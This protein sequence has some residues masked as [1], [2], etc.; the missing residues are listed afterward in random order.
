[1]KDGPSDGGGE[2]LVSLT[3]GFMGTMADGQLA[4]RW[5]TPECSW[6]AAH[7]REAAVHLLF[8]SAN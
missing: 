3:T 1:M 7:L 4:A 8:S 5:D 6:P 2:D